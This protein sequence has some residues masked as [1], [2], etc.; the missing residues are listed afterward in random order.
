MKMQI[1]K[2]GEK[3]IPLHFYHS[4][5]TVYSSKNNIGLHY[6]RRLNSYLNKKRG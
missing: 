5:V 1:K 2:N 3:T 4:C 6:G